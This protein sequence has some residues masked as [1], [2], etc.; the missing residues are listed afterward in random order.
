MRKRM[1]PAGGGKSALMIR[2]TRRSPEKTFS[3]YR[4]FARS[5]DRIFRSEFLLNFVKRYQ[6]QENRRNTISKQQKVDRRHKNFDNHF[7]LSEKL[8]NFSNQ[9]STF[10]CSVTGNFC[11]HEVKLEFIFHCD[12]RVTLAWGRKVF[13]NMGELLTINLGGFPFNFLNPRFHIKFPDKYFNLFHLKV[14]GYS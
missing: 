3:N 8:M 7:R 6:Q 1:D 2:W 10:S 5:D 13:A 14:S 12:V 11:F 9:L 4:D